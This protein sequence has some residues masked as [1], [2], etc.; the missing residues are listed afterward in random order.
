M[1][2]ILRNLAT[3]SYANGFDLWCYKSSTDKIN[4]I[5]SR[6]YFRDADDILQPGD[7]I[8]VNGVDGSTILSV[9]SETIVTTSPLIFS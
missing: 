7:M 3:L 9:K 8:M 5:S 4:D 2:F 6:Y 1:A